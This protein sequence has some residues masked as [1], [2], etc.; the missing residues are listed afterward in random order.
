MRPGR[1]GILLLAGLGLSA[2]SMREA[3]RKKLVEFGWDVPYPDE[4]KERVREMEER[5][6]DGILLRLREYGEAFDTRRWDEARLAPQIETLRGVAWKRFN[7]N[8]LLLGATNSFGM[9]WFDDGQWETIRG[10]LRLAARAARAGRCVGIALDPEP[11]GPNPWRYDGPSAGRPFEEVAAAVRRRGA[12]FLSA[13]QA[14]LPGLRL[15][16]L[17]E[18]GI[19]GDLAG[20]QDPS[21]RR[22]RLSAGIYALLPAFLDGMLDAAAPGT[23]I[24]DGNEPSYY[25]GSRQDFLRGR[26]RVTRGARDLVAPELRERYSARVEAGMAVYADYVLARWRPDND[27]PSRYAAP[28][29]RLRWLEHNVFWALTTSD[30]YVWFY[31][32]RM[33]W[34]SGE[35]PRG[36]EKAIRS[37][38]AKVERGLPLGFEL[39]GTVARARE[40]MESAVASR[41]ESRSARIPRLRRGEAP[42][43]VDGD[44]GDGVW[45]RCRPLRPFRLRARAAR[46]TPEAG[47][48]AWAAYDD[49][50]LYL[51]FRCEEPDP[52]RLEAALLGAGRGGRLPDR[53]EILLSLGEAPLP[54]R[55]F[56]VAPG[57]APGVA[58]SAARAGERGWTA[59]V[60]IPWD[61]VGGPPARGA[62]RRANLCRD[63]ASARELSCWSVV[64][65][66]SDGEPGRSGTWSF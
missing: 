43:R 2:L 9:D 10:N 63:R 41:L 17:F 24:V 32:E 11:Y 26:E 62:T 22:A 5:P 38:R 8:F 37:A 44:L 45:H 54:N 16:T 12:E 42:P 66:D 34:W 49:E 1:F 30:E 47:T 14:E 51:A 56:S 40:R 50:A 21:A 23:T 48:V 55:S 61:A 19:F 6:F 20:E 46:E 25:Y 18:L 15:L 3:P 57:V 7:D 27:Y 64:L 36:V 60:A 39:E 31:G 28:A 29:D 4:V 52:A 13:L 33:N 65:E 35:V 58:S 59:E 53:V